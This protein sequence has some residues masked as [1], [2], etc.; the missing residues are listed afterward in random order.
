[1][2]PVSIAKLVLAVA[3]IVVFLM[4]ASSGIPMLRW[5]GTALVLIAWLL[6]FADR[7]GPRTDSRPATTNDPSEDP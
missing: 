5:T 1:M 6:R 3:G 2:S 4:G 7:A